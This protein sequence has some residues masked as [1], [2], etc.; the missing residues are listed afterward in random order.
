M[1]VIIGFLGHSVDI[2]QMRYARRNLQL[3]ADA[4][5]TAAPNHSNNAYVEVV[6]TQPQ[7]TYFARIFSFNSVPVA[8]S[9]EAPSSRVEAAAVLVPQKINA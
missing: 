5:G 4:L 7:T 3:A 1:A 6:P 8:A 9:M 2:G